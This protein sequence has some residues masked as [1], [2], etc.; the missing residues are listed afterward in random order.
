MLNG[1]NKCNQRWDYYRGIE[2]EASIDLTP[3]IESA[4]MI[5]TEP[6]A[7][8]TIGYSTERLEMIERYLSAHFYTLRDPRAESEKAGSVASKYQ[9]KVDLGYN[10]SHYGQMALR[11]DTNGGLASSE[12]SLR[13]GISKSTAVGI[14]HAGKI[15]VE[16]ES[17]AQRSK[18]SDIQQ[19]EQ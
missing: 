19:T 7:A 3:F 17:Q 4:N 12:A 1:Q 14:T 2:V 15:T 13:K 16:Q 9:S 10:A 6:C 8:S 18:K 5:V 11:L